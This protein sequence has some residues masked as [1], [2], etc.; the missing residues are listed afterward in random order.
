[1]V[2]FGAFMAAVWIYPK[3]FYGHIPGGPFRIGIILF[4]ISGVLMLYFTLMQLKRVE[5]NKE[6]GFFYVTNY[7]KNVR[8]PFHNIDKIEES[9]F[10]F[11]QLV[12]IHLKTPGSFGKVIRFVASRKSY[13]NFW[14]ENPELGKQFIEKV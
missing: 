7:F 8:Y 10:L 2:F 13:R 4:F 3:A 5:I 14:Q 6:E 9:D 1:M 12:S 11:L